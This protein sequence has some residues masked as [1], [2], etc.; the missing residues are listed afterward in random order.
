MGHT[1]LNTADHW[2]D[3]GLQASDISSRAIAVLAGQ[4][5]FGV[6][7]FLLKDGSVVLNEIAPRY[8]D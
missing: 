4:G 7:L 2:P 3:V 5:I 6:E 8:T 1:Y